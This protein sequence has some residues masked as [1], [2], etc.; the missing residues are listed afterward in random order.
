MRL[1]ED[2]SKET[3]MAVFMVHVCMLLERYLSVHRFFVC[4]SLQDIAANVHIVGL[5]LWHSVVFYVAADVSVEHA[6]SI[7]TDETT[8]TLKIQV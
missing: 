6:T 7:F 5:G 2:E 8:A 1:L 3:L 4:H